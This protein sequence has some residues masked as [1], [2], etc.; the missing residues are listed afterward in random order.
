MQPAEAP[1][2]GA[3][4]HGSLPRPLQAP[5][6]EQGKELHYQEDSQG[7]ATEKRLA[8]DK[9]RLSQPGA[10]ADNVTQA[11]RL[12]PSQGALCVEVSP[13]RS[14]SQGTRSPPTNWQGQEGKTERSPKGRHGVESLGTSS[15]PSER[16]ES[17][18]LHS[19]DS[20]GRGPYARAQVFS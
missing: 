3:A 9:E 12:L 2:A 4:K 16:T 7:I 5:P 8:G 20:S 19:L 10:A 17:S 13:G 6:L 14:H 18:A 15:P 1:R 11:P